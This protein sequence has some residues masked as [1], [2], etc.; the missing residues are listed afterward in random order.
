MFTLFLTVPLIPESGDGIARAAACSHK[1]NCAAFVARSLVPYVCVHTADAHNG[2]GGSYGRLWPGAAAGAL[3]T[4]MALP[5]KSGAI[6][7]PWQDRI[8]TPREA[9]RLQGFP[10]SFDLGV[11]A[12]LD[13]VTAHS[14]AKE[15]L[16]R[17]TAT[18]KVVASISAP[19][20]GI[21]PGEAAD[22]RRQ[23]ASAYISVAHHVIGNAVPPPF[24][25]ALARAISESRW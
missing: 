7:H 2:W 4:T 19:A 5:S 13:G 15:G 24:S 8:F 18:S 9:A 14:T 21:A 3:L 10:D 11:D 17:A 16:S 1:A 25:A 22:R 20:A 12:A 6:I 23:A